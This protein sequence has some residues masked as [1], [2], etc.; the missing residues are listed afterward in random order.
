MKSQPKEEF[1]LRG[2]LKSPCCGGNMTAGWTKGKCKY[3]IYYRCIKH[4]H[5]N[6]SGAVL[7]EKFNQLLYLLSFTQ[8]Q[9]KQLTSQVKNGLQEALNISTQQ[10]KV[11]EEQLSSLEIKI[12]RAEEKFMNDEINEHTYDK[13]SRKYT[14]E[15]VRLKEKISC[16]K[17]NVEEQVNRELRL[18]PNLLNLSGLFNK[19]TINQQHAIL[20]AVFKGSL[21]FSDGTFRTPTI[22][23]A[24]DHNVLKLKEKKIVNCRTIF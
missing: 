21:T 2:I 20:K 10:L 6:I 14:M 22:N 1:P 13:W 23:P 4:S 19:A 18:L 12:N 8:L 5:V 15:R 9:I 24:F 3:Y 11:K 17:E 7:H 16:L